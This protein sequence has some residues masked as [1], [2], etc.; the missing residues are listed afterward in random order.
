MTSPTTSPSTTAS[1]SS[2]PLLAVHALT[3]FVFCPRAGIVAV[4]NDWQQEPELDRTNLGFYLPVDL[5]DLEH[6]LNDAL[7]QFWRWVACVVVALVAAIVASWWNQ[8]LIAILGVL[9][10]ILASYP[11]RIGIETVLRLIAQHR[12]LIAWQAREPR[13]D[14]ET[15]HPVDWRDILRS[16]WMTIRCPEAYRD[17]QRGLVG[18]PW[19]IIRHGSITIPVWRFPQHATVAEPQ[20][21]PQHLVRMAAYC[22]LITECEGRQSPCGIVLFGDSYLGTTLPFDAAAQGRLWKAYEDARAILANVDAD[23]RWKPPAPSANLC[24][25]CPCGAPLAYRELHTEFRRNGE[26]IPVYGS[27]AADQKLYHS[28]CGDRFEWKPPHE[29]AKN[30]GIA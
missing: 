14:A 8:P 5:A 22:H 15:P 7:N 6:R 10:C 12:E 21:Y 1:A 20:I 30:L 25:G 26:Y 29:R 2:V 27:T 13:F 23:D 3:E 28:P 16:G 9:A 19:C 18:K 11:L 17:D 24:S 4:E